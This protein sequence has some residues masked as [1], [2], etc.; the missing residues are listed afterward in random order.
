[1]DL[2]RLD[3]S[4]FVVCIGC[5]VI[6]TILVLMMIWGESKNRDWLWKLWSSDIAVFVSST[7]I[8]AIS[9]SLAKQP[10]PPPLPPRE[11]H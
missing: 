4:F 8:W 5:I 3:K 10:Y 1:M 7:L 11:G 2:K 9:R 6:A